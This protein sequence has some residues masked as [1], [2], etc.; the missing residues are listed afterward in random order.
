MGWIA[1][2][3]D[4]SDDDE[5]VRALEEDAAAEHLWATGELP[6]GWLAR[7]LKKSPPPLPKQPKPIEV[8]ASALAVGRTEAASLLG[9]STDTL[10][11]YVIPK[12]RVAYIGKRQLIPVSELKAF[13]EAASRMA[14]TY[15]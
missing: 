1:G 10:D 13:V 9:I 11:R 4:V 6:D 14:L 3:G 5:L 15:G 2:H 7:E 8:P 12:I